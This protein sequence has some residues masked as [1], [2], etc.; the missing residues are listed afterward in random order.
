MLVALLL[1]V[2]LIGRR[3]QPRFMAEPS[4][5][6]ARHVALIAA[7]LTMLLIA[8][9][10]GG[11]D[12][13]GVVDDEGAYLL[14][15]DLFAHGRWTAPSPASFISFTQPGV[16]VTPVIAPKM[17]PGHA[18]LL[19]PGSLLGLP[20]LV[21]VILSGLAAAL[22]VIVAAECQS[23]GVAVL[24]VVLWLTSAGQMRWRAS[25]FSEITTGTLWLIGWWALLRWRQ[26]RRGGWLLAIAAAIGWGAI[27]R[28]LTMLAYAVPVG[29]VVMIDVVRIGLWRQLAAAIAVG[30]GCL[31][32]L[33]IQNKAVL[34]NWRSSPLQL[35]T[36]QYIP[37]DV[38]GFG[39]D[40]T[41]PTLHLPAKLQSE[42]QPFI[43][44]HR[45]HVWRDLPRELV[46][47]LQRAAGSTFLGWRAIWIPAALVGAVLI[48]GPGWF[49]VASGLMLYI[50][51][52]LYAH[53][54]HWTVYY[55]E[56]SPI[57]AFVVATGLAWVLA[58]ATTGRGPLSLSTALGAAAAIVIVAWPE[59]ATTRVYRSSAQAPFRALGR[60][61]PAAV[62]SPVLV[63]VRY[64]PGHDPT[65]NLVRNVVD[66]EHAPV[67]TA[68]DLG[69][70]ANTHAA[71]AFP[72]RRVLY[73]DADARRIVPP[74]SALAKA[75][76]LP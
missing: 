6:R 13:P 46:L 68:L 67:I 52:L 72:G 37:F 1:G 48:G 26:T 59:V 10:W 24:T 76:T 19:A 40:S 55:L 12:A 9:V 17:V 69:G 45:E 7:I 15:A 42:M 21:P 8:W 56:A 16:L 49:A 11:L 58:R 65:V 66:P 33:P 34:G 57:P 75:G 41:P 54:P 20:G 25:Y 36:R 74:D 18:L 38:L 32:L 73:W 4:S 50:A 22:L 2:V 35:Y 29:I 28:P 23:I 39:Y 47:R 71:E 31:S 44:R 5:I 14:Q 61:V 43:A 27:T 51:Y 30:L 3:W 60:A 70:A 64:E 53:E 62:A 63:F